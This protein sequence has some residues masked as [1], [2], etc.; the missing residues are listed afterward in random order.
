MY[1]S[2]LVNISNAL[3]MGLYLFNVVIILHHLKLYIKLLLKKKNA[4]F[5]LI[6]TLTSSMVAKTAILCGIGSLDRGFPDILQK[7]TK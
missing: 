1:L 6:F 7:T 5:H 2:L 4:Y 3:L